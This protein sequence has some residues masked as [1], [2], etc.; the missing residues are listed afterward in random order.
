MDLC[1]HII[2]Y[3]KKEIAGFMANQKELIKEAVEY[4]RYKAL[5]LRTIHRLRENGYMNHYTDLTDEEV[6]NWWTSKQSIRH[7][8]CEHK[9]Q[10]YLFDDL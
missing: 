9:L 5:I 8:Y 10:G 3:H 7:W 2:I 1:N 6:F 4:P